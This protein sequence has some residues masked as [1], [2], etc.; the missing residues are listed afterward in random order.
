MLLPLC[1]LA[2]I[3]VF[4]PI[5]LSLLFLF[6]ICLVQLGFQHFFFVTFISTSHSLIHPFD[7][8]RC[9]PF[10]FNIFKLKTD[11]L[12]VSATSELSLHLSPLVL[13]CLPFCRHTDFLCTFYFTSPSLFS[14]SMYKNTSN[15]LL[16]NC[17]HY[18]N[19]MLT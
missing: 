9:A 12:D 5:F 14:S 18:W 8:R 2:A 7:W 3:S 4:H 16:V 1:P 17:C 11:T 6:I 15:L 19:S 13:F 10:L